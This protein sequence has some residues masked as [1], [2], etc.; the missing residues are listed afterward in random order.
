MVDQMSAKHAANHETGGA[1]RGKGGRPLVGNRP[2]TSSERSKRSRLRRRMARQAEPPPIDRVMADVT[3]ESVLHDL[4]AERRITTGFHR[5]IAL[6]I[7]NALANDELALAEKLLN[8]LP[9]VCAEVSHSP[10]HGSS[11]LDDRLWE[12]IASAIAAD[13]VEQAPELE[14]LRAEVARLKAQIGES[15][16]TPPAVATDALAAN[17]VETTAAPKVI[18]PP[19]SAIIPP[20]EIGVPRPIYPDDP[21][22][23]PGRN[24]IIDAEP[25]KA[26]A[27]ERPPQGAP[28]P[29]SWDDSPNGQAWKAWREAGGYGGD[30]YPAPFS[31]NAFKPVY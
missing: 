16:V 29:Q 10:T 7:V 1:K 25:V 15:P 28:A 23:K 4:I 26:A 24:T 8:H 19:T 18:D 27:P 11:S 14:R 12:G 22:P 21:K 30:G 3:S 20:G 17:A 6:K 31:G 9:A 2:M 5:T 13:E